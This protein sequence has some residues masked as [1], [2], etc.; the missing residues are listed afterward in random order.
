[1]PEREVYSARDPANAEI[2]KD[3][4]EAHGIPA[5]VHG[6]YLWGGVG[7]LPADVYPTI[8]VINLEDKNEARR[9]LKEFE[10]GTT[11][12]GTPWRCPG[13]H[14]KLEPQFDVCWR[15]GARRET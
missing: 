12:R 11:R 3:F 6:Y 1:M 2:V 5:E 10:A 7:Q 13:C 9:L 15:C 8:W 14:E 4:L